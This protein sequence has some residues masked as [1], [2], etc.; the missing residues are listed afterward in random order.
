VAEVHDEEGEECGK[1]GVEAGRPETVVLLCCYRLAVCTITGCTIPLSIIDPGVG[2][3]Y[4]LHSTSF[5]LRR[6]VLFGRVAYV[7][8]DLGFILISTPVNSLSVE[9]TCFYGSMTDCSLGHSAGLL[10]RRL[11][12]HTYT[13]PE[14]FV[15]LLSLAVE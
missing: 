15:W 7:Q 2:I 3:R 4:F 14:L 8:L 12:I 9:L 11:T 10:R 1:E 6:W 5:A 13:D